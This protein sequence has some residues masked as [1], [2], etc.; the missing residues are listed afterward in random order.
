MKRLDSKDTGSRFIWAKL[1]FDDRG[2]IIK[3]S[4]EKQTFLYDSPISRDYRG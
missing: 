1:H 4:I 2:R 3:Q